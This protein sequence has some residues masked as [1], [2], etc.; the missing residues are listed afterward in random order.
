MTLYKSIMPYFD[1][2]L[3]VYG[4]KLSKLWSP[5]KIWTPTTLTIANFGHPAVSKSWLRPCIQVLQGRSVIDTEESDCI[6][7]RGPHRYDSTV[8]VPIQLRK[9]PVSNRIKSSRYFFT[10]TMNEMPLCWYSR[11]GGKECR[12]AGSVGKYIAIASSSGGRHFNCTTIDTNARSSTWKSV[13]RATLC[14]LHG[15]SP[16]P[17]HFSKH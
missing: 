2:V 4:W 17:P 1:K 6:D 11:Q 8:R 13:K 9:I 16:A 14:I 7:D 3:H 10:G 15:A 12:D 5:L